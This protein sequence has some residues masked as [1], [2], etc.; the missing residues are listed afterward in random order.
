MSDKESLV[1]LTRA[2]FSKH[3]GSGEA[4]PAWDFSWNWCG[5]VPNYL[6]GGVYALLKGD[7]VL[8]I[9]VG[10]SRGAGIYLE[11]V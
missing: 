8:Y 11:V 4:V 6:L 2:F 7:T 10:T 1:R 3:W 9:G 5:P